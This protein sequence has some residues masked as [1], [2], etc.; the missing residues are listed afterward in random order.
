MKRFHSFQFDT[1]N[2]CLWREGERLVL[3]RKAFAVMR[4]LV[5][6]AGRLVTKEELM[7]AVWPGT[8]VQEEILRTYIRKLRQALGDNVRHPSFIETHT[9]RGYRFIAPVTQEEF[10]APN[11][12]AGQRLKRLFGRDSDLRRLQAFFKKA[13]AGERQIVFITGEPGI[14][15][16]ALTEAFLQQVTAQADLRLATGQCIEHYREQEAYY[17]VL[18]AIGR[19]CH[20]PGAQ[21]MIELLAQYAPTWLVQFP[22]VVTPALRKALQREILGATRERMLRELCEALEALTAETP[23]ILAFEDLH[24][25]DYSTLGLIS[26]LARRG[27]AAR[28]LVLATYRPVEVILAE[29]PLKQLKQELRIQRR[30][31]ELP[32]EL[33]NEVAVAEYLSAQFP[34]N[35]FPV[36]LARLLH[37][38]IAGNP[39]FMVTAVEYMVAHG[40]LTEAR[41]TATWRLDGTL[42]Q[43][44]SAV[45]RSVQQIIQRLIEQLTAEE[46]EMLNVA[47]V[48]GVE[49]TAN[50]VAAGAGRDSA[51]TEECFDSLTERQ[52]V[53]R[54]A[55][56]AELPDGTVCG[57]YQFT[58]SLYREALYHRLSPAVKVRL[59]QRIGEELERRGASSPAEVASEL[60]HHFQESRDHARSVRYL[61]LEA[62]T[63]ARRYAYREAV[64]LLESA[65]EIVCKLP[66]PTRGPVELEVLEQLATVQDTTGERRQAAKLY[67][68][69]AQCAARLGQDEVQARALTNAA[70]QIRWF[71]PETA[72][73]I[74][75]RALQIASQLDSPVLKADCQVNTCFGRLAMLGWREDWV[76]TAKRS[77]DWMRDAGELECFARNAYIS[78]HVRM[79]GG[80]YQGAAQVAAEGASA[81][82]EVGAT[83]SYFFACFHRGWALT[84]LGEFG[85]S[86]SSLQEAIRVADQHGD[87]ILMAFVK[88]ILAGLHCEAFDFAGARSLCQ[89]ALSVIRPAQFTVAL[90]WALIS[91]ATAEAGTGDYDRVL[92]YLLELQMLYERTE[93]PFSWYW[94]MPMH[95]SQCEVWLARKELAAARREAEL[96]RELSN[97]TSERAWQARTRQMSAR[98]A[99]AER[100]WVRAES[101]ITEAL[102]MIEGLAAPLAAW[103][104]YDTATELYELTDR[105]DSAVHYRDLRNA[106][107][108]SLANSLA[109]GE[110]LRQS[111]L[112]A[113][114]KPTSQQ[115]MSMTI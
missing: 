6:Q 4:C 20:A 73:E 33:L 90:E 103:R 85:G 37:R 63:V 46:R 106:K 58:H 93:V 17:P 77:L 101:E 57:A 61:R 76:E 81:A 107:L 72:L 54:D 55:G 13:L 45:P 104:I 52:L 9:G 94:Q 79:V 51:S 100:D 32:L 110:P 29:H 69:L 18:E 109:E 111:I 44:S 22:S 14:G 66:E 26:A 89:D 84:S 75:E 24:W 36:D 50:A 28:L 59:H 92:E 74:N 88:A 39:L 80:D 62:A 49:F 82:I 47:A 38:Q 5:E 11:D 113:I 43:V 64:A 114:S 70:N 65:R 15:K 7:E 91:A 78:A 8:Y 108:L 96:L 27:E 83:L 21:K 3:T 42:E 48:A 87:T 12:G 31:E 40:L 16:T 10:V 25:A 102:A 23:L 97:Q 71:A 60:A 95:T 99:L 2:E 53:L 105:C 98:V 86:S 115:P 1:V 19:L 67:K 34:D 68:E 41:E 30:S 35:S 56:L 112:N